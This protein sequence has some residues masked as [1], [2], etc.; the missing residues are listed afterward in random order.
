MADTTAQDLREVAAFQNWAGLQTWLQNRPCAGAP[1]PAF[2]ILWSNHGPYTLAGLSNAELTAIAL[3]PSMM[4][5]G[6]SG[7]T[8][9][10]RLRQQYRT[11][12]VQV[13]YLLDK[14][15][16][17]PVAIDGHYGPLT[18]AAVKKY[19]GDHGIQPLGV[20]GPETWSSL[21]GD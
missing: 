13:Q 20:V 4:S 2:V 21:F 5:S 1:G 16:Y 7:Q 3:G 9:S 14:D 18:E 12:V 8:I 11:D 17:G 15:G 10:T 6:W 19:Q